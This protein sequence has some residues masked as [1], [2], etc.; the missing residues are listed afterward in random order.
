[1]EKQEICVVRRDD[2]SKTRL[3]A[4]ISESSNSC[5]TSNKTPVGQGVQRILDEMHES[6]YKKASEEM[7]RR[8]VFI[9]E[10]DPM[11]DSL[12][13]KN[14]VMVPWCSSRACEEEI[15]RKTTVRENGEVILTG[16]KTLC[17]PFEAP[18]FEGKKC[19]GC[20]N[21]ADCY[22]LFGRSY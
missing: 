22:A 12:N 20:S 2:G 13:K 1:L 7:N 17:I 9:D 5:S 8:T 11:L 21:A 6:L 19:I 10:F 14:I 18:S 3:P 16:A 15:G 4:A